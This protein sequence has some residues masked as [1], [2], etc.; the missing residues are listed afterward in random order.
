[1]KQNC[2]QSYSKIFFCD[3]RTKNK[4]RWK[5]NFADFYEELDP[6][7]ENYGKAAEERRKTATAHL[8]LDVSITQLPLQESNI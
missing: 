4:C 8:S 1:M 5:G 2:W 6:M 3:E 7:L